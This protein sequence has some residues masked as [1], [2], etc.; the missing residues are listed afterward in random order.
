MAITGLHGT[1]IVNLEGVGKLELKDLLSHHT[2]VLPAPLSW[3]PERD[4]AARATSTVPNRLL[5][6]PTRDCIL[7]GR[8]KEDGRDCHYRQD[9]ARIAPDRQLRE[10]GSCL[11]ALRAGAAAAC[12][13]ARTDGDVVEIGDDP[14]SREEV[15][16]FRQD[17]FWLVPPGD[18]GEQ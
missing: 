3:V 11:L 12:R 16:R 17:R 14:H 7:Q 5:S 6:S 2:L 8:N 10:A 15:R 13:A 9:D 18:V 1:A 4:A